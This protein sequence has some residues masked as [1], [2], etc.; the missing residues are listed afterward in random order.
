MRFLAAFHAG[1]RSAAHPDHPPF[2]FLLAG[3]LAVLAGTGG[4]PARPAPGVAAKLVAGGSPMGERGFAAAGRAMAAGDYAR[5]A[6][7]FRD[8]ADGGGDPDACL[9]RLA[10][11]RYRL[12]DDAGALDACA[13]A[14]HRTAGKSAWAPFVHGLVEKRAGAVPTARFY[15]EVAAVRGHPFAEAQLRR[16]AP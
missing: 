3:V 16:L 9:G 10:E 5:A 4:R 15:F 12:R 1:L 13:E 8:A 2:L 6:G 14:E 11:C 7:L